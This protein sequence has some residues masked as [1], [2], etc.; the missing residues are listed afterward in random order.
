MFVLFALL[1]SCK[2]TKY[3][4]D[5][6]FLLNNNN[7]EFVKDSLN[8]QRKINLE[9]LNSILKQQPNRKLFLGYRFHLNLYNLSNQSRID[10]AILRK[11]SD[12]TKKREKIDNK[13]QRKSN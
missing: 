13:N 8:H 7:I 12:S 2:L 6:Q 5:D 10:R 4:P 1:S 9:D 11:E 3:V